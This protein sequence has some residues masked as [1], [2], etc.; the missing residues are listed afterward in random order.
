MSS[1]YCRGSVAISLT[2]VGQVFYPRYSV[3]CT[4]YEMPATRSDAEAMAAVQLT[5]GFS[6]MEGG[7]QENEAA[8]CFLLEVSTC[9][10]C[11]SDEKRGGGGGMIP[12][13]ASEAI[14]NSVFVENTLAGFSGGG[15]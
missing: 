9:I 4:R 12:N 1:E 8:G 14:S 5:A 10:E 2:S 15:G 6:R 7:R 13:K 11:L 3:L